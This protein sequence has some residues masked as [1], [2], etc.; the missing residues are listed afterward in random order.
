MSQNTI[1]VAFI[2]NRWDLCNKS[3]P[4]QSLIKLPRKIFLFFSFDSLG[5]RTRE[6]RHTRLLSIISL[7]KKD[8][9][10]FSASHFPEVVHLALTAYVFSNTRF[11]PTLISLFLSLLIPSLSRAELRSMQRRG[12]H[13]RRSVN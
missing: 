5:L 9:C 8:R 6:Q 7:S 12:L 2:M 13:R 10:S 11:S 3:H 1:Q 4:L